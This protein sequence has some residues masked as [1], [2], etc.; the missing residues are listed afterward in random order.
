MA[1]LRAGDTF[2]FP[3]A[4]RRHLHIILTD[5][6]LDSGRSMVVSVITYHPLL[7]DMETGCLLRRGDHP[8]ITH[9]ST[10]CW[11]K[12]QIGP[13]GALEKAADRGEIEL[14][15]RIADP[16]VLD[17]LLLATRRAFNLPSECAV[18]LERVFRAIKPSEPG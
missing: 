16:K 15:E 14:R 3:T 5:P 1:T 8:S 13:I 11:K 9:D 6:A 10:I 4:R 12:S 7:P 18:H 2:V 17:R